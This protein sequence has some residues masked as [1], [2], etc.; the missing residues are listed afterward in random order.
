MSPRML[1]LREGTER[2]T[3]RLQ[4]SRH[5][6]FGGRN[7]NRSTVCLAIQNDLGALPTYEDNLRPSIRYYLRLH[8]SKN[9]LQQ[10]TQRTRKL[11]SFGSNLEGKKSTDARHV[12]PAIIVDANFA[13]A[14][15]A[16]V[17]GVQEANIP[18]I[19]KRREEIGLEMVGNGLG[20][21]RSEIPSLKKR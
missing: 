11:R 16:R 15:N 5:A 13:I 18:W 14:G 21:L 20:Y 10:T 2:K 6:I 17:R 9:R 12:L 8:I 7:T 1:E 19:G 4:K 3:G